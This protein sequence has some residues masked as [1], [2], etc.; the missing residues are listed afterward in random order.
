MSGLCMYIDDAGERTR[1]HLLV[2]LY[3]A[4]RF[5]ERQQQRTA[6]VCNGY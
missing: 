5:E 4:I 1:L 3:I 6:V 2:A